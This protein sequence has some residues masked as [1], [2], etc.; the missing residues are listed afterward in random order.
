[1]QILLFSNEAGAESRKLPQK[2]GILQ[3]GQIASDF[4][5]SISLYK[6]ELNLLPNNRDNFH[7]IKRNFSYPVQRM[8][9]TSSPRTAF[10]KLAADLENL[11]KH[12]KST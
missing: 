5:R 7:D 4:W 11:H 3:D 2:G 8:K 1:M 10:M 6:K 9:S 12:I